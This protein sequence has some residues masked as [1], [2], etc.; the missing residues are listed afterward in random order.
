MYNYQ[1]C[2]DNYQEA[3]E[4]ITFSPLQ[5]LTTGAFLGLDFLENTA[6]IDTLAQESFNSYCHNNNI[7]A[8]SYWNTYLYYYV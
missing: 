6:A 2:E 4:T 3:Q 7:K 8:R 1:A 5:T